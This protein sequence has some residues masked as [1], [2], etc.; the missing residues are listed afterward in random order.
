MYLY[1]E[2]IVGNSSLIL[3]VLSDFRFF[4]DIPSNS[5]KNTDIV[6]IQALVTS[7]DV[8]QELKAI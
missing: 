7:W 1:E 4:A 5:I 2:K 8:S 3:T 6:E